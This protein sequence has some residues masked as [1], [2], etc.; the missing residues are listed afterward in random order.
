MG[1]WT[2][3]LLMMIYLFDWRAHTQYTTLL[4]SEHGSKCTLCNDPL[5]IIYSYTHTFKYMQRE[6]E[7]VK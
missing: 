5:H 7:T 1:E 3:G 2:M 6:R 4:K